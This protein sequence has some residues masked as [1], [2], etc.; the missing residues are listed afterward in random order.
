M[1]ILDSF[2]KPDSLSEIGPAM[3]S[4][5]VSG[6]VMVLSS[7]SGR[8]EITAGVKLSYRVYKNKDTGEVEINIGL[9]IS[10]KNTMYV[11]APIDSDPFEREL[12]GVKGNLKAAISVSYQKES[13]P[14]G[15]HGATVSWM[16]TV[17]RGTT[18]ADV[19]CTQYPK[20]KAYVIYF[21]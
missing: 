1:K 15:Q 13:F 16:G 6:E 21:N 11:T 5:L 12:I 17:C 3:D 8:Y 7:G 19:S 4:P 20:T 18:G 9:L 10:G 2:S 14:N